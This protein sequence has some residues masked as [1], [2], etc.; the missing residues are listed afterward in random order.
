MYSTFNMGVGLC[1][2]APAAEE[3]A[4]V[5]TFRRHGLEAF[6]FGVVSSGTGVRVG[7]TRLNP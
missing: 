7:R 1:V 4:I 5:R 3:E 6:D 2:C